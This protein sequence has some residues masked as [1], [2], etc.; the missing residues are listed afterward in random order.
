MLITIT[1][2]VLIDYCFKKLMDPLIKVTQWPQY[3]G[4]VEQ[5][6][7]L[8]EPRLIK[9]SANA[10]GSIAVAIDETSCEPFRLKLREMDNLENV[11][12]EIRGLSSGENNEEKDKRM[13]DILHPFLAFMETITNLDLTKDYIN[14]NK[15]KYPSCF[16]FIS[17]LLSHGDDECE[18]EPHEPILAHQHRFQPELQPD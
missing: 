17:V 1:N 13:N 9:L 8:S 6:S 12:K 11:L 2:E 10:L 4:E 15:G 5:I 18:G 16:L 3:P 14:S 7:E